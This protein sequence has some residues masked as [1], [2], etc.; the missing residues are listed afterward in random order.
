MAEVKLQE[1][2]ASW[3]MDRVNNAQIKRSAALHS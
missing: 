1:I 2:T 3:A